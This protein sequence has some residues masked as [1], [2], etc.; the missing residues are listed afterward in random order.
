MPDW[1]GNVTSAITQ[2]SRLRQELPG[3]PSMNLRSRPECLSG[4]GLMSRTACLDDLLALCVLPHD[5]S[6]DRRLPR[7]QSNLQGSQTPVANILLHIASV[8]SLILLAGTV[9]CSEATRIA[10]FPNFSLPY[11]SILVALSSPPPQ[12]PGQAFVTDNGSIQMKISTNTVTLAA[13]AKRALA[14]YGSRL[15]P[16]SDDQHRPRLL[17][18][19]LRHRH[20]LMLDPPLYVPR[21]GVPACDWFLLTELAVT[22][23]S[24]RCL[25][26]CGNRI[27]C[28]FPSQI[29]M[30]SRT[31]AELPPTVD[32]S[33]N[34]GVAEIWSE[35]S[36]ALPN[37]GRLVVWGRLC[38]GDQTTIIWQDFTVLNPRC[39]YVN[40]YSGQ[41]PYMDRSLL[42]RYQTSSL[43]RAIR[44]AVCV[45]DTISC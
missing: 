27:G 45:T 20:H 35:C 40:N 1:F 16:L 44:R 29:C 14:V 9:E 39:S 11:L 42:S 25:R 32:G 24:R 21:P 17:R 41:S 19:C 22:S 2:Q 10:E 18:G 38:D 31:L 8:V 6:P 4:Q 37:L 36:R 34:V 5:Y 26:S 43:A 15:S 7:G 13:E 12:P 3:R 28:G 30:A 33:R 23:Q